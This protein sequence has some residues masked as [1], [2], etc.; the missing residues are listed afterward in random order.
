MPN[1]SFDHLDKLGIF[2]RLMT[3][4]DIEGQISVRP[5]LLAEGLEEFRPVVG[6]LQILAPS[7]PGRRPYFEPFFYF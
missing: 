2:N 7:P 6:I 4:S 5:T 1:S 3:L